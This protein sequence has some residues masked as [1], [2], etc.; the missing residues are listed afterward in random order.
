MKFKN[1]ITESIIDTLK[2]SVAIIDSISEK[3]EQLNDTSITIPADTLK[4]IID[5][6]KHTHSLEV[7]LVY[8]SVVESGGFKIQDSRFKIQDSRFKIQESLL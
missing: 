4:N 1:L 8:R 6:K 7:S 5:K 2:L 3:I